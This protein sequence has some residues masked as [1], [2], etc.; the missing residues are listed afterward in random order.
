MLHVREQSGDEHEVDRP[1]TNDLE[2]DVD[3]GTLRVANLGTLHGR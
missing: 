2:G 3:I 1:I